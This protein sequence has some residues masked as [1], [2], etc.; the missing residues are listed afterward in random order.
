MSS[1]ARVAGIPA[2]SPAGICRDQRRSAI[3]LVSMTGTP[4]TPRPERRLIALISTEG[5]SKEQMKAAAHQAI[6]KYL[7]S[8]G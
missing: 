5:K 6:Q 2:E 4:D 8:K 1:F 7:E 3:T